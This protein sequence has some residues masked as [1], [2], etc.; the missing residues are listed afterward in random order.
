[1]KRIPVILVAV[2]L[3]LAFGSAAFAQSAASVAADRQVQ[4]DKA[5]VR[6]DREKLRRDRHKLNV[7]K[8]KARAAAL[9]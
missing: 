8:R 5:Q 1:M 2:A 3:S 6:A 9:K 7:D 4:K